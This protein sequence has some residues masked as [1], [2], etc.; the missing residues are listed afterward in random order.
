MENNP[1]Q[2]KRALLI[3]DNS[4]HA[5]HARSVLGKHNIINATEYESLSSLNVIRK[6]FKDT[7]NTVFI[8]KSFSRMVND[9]GP[10]FLIILDYRIDL[11]PES[12]HDSDH[13][14]LLRTFFISLVIMMKKGEL[15]N[16]RINFILLTDK[17]DFAEMMNFQKNPVAILDILQSDNQ[18]INN[19]IAGIRQDPAEFNR[20]FSIIALPNIA[21][22]SSFEKAII[23]LIKENDTSLPA[24]Q[25]VAADGAT[26]PKPA[27]KT[28]PAEPPVAHI[29]FRINDTLAYVDGT[30]V[31][32]KDTPALRSLAIGQFYVLGRWE[33][34]NQAEVAKSF[35][36]YITKG[37]GEKRFHQND[38][39]VINLSDHCTIDA[40]V[41]ASL[42]MLFTKQLSMYNTRSI[43]VSYKN[44][45]I[46]EKGSGFIL[47]KKYVR[48]AY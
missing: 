41:I 26:S 20:I 17:M 34:K 36:E 13:R 46:L 5:S 25:Q 16:A 33:N 19:L 38:E 30:K 6:S 21:F 7:R 8:R 47:I 39:I 31:P 42:V 24:E 9:W 14:K 27:K 3:T 15:K 22:D 40:T 32:T 35:G 18:E 12:I 28:E 43:V 4:A 11:G 10:P 44:A 37:I 48:H 45:D 1:P 29:V 2:K 23:A